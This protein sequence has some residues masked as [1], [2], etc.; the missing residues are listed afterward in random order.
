MCLV[1]SLLLSDQGGGPEVTFQGW[2]SLYA[3]QQL[4]TAC[5]C[6]ACRDPEESPGTVVANMQYQLTGILEIV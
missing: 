3:P 1:M 6:T 4:L 5:I 2:H